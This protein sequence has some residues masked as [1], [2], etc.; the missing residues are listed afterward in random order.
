MKVSKN[1]LFC[2]SMIEAAHELITNY[3][4]L[5]R[6]KMVK[7]GLEKLLSEECYEA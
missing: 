2:R 1:E 7:N 3:M 5:D 6:E 4:E